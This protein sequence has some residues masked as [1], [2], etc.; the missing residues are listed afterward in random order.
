M[1]KSR[2]FLEQRQTQTAERLDPRWQ[3]VRDQPVMESGNIHYEVAGRIHAIG[4]GGLGMLQ[5]VVDQTGL[6]GAIDILE[7]NWPL[8][9]GSA[10]STRPPD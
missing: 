10:A 5:V 4:C 9:F 3:P 1:S 6:R 2:T 7:T 8:R